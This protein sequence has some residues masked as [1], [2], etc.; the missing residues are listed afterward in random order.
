MKTVALSRW[1]V[2]I[3]NAEP[4]VLFAGNC[5]IEGEKQT[6]ETARRLKQI[7]EEL[8]IP[9]VFK[10]SYDKAN[11][12]SLKSYRGPGLK[13]GLKILSAVK[14]RYGLPLLVDV[15]NPSEARQVAEVADVLQIPA[16]LC[17]QTDLL[18]ACARTGLPVNVKKGQFM[19]PEDMENAVKKIE[20]S[21]NNKTL[22]T[23]RGSTF[24]YHN[25]VVDMRS[26]EI[27]KKTGCPV[28]FDATHSVQL[29]GGLGRSSGGQR[30]FIGTLARAAVAAGVAGIFVEVH[31]NPA[32]ALSDGPNSLKMKD[33]PSM[34]K[35][36][37]GID[38]LVKRV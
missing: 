38:K 33:L 2:N 6:L 4:M 26:I 30:K 3:G 15:H 22:L 27:M 34:L 8:S 20:V 1:N 37:I 10:A 25:L 11:R 19:A 18:T 21:G 24:G 31:E 14:K 35:T 23:E 28:I 13:K 17:R 9:L 5:V 32:K 36:L 12:S 29:P 7:S 16:F